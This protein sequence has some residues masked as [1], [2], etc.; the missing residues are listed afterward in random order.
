MNKSNAAAS[1]TP[2]AVNCPRC[3]ASFVCGMAADWKTCWCAELPAVA[4][5]DP[6]RAECLCP[7]CL[8]AITLPPC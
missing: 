4:P 3:G 2:G 6:S 1:P 7:D 5:P 8:R